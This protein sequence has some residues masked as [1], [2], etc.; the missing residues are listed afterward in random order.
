[1]A[2]RESASV[3]ESRGKGGLLRRR[4]HMSA[5]TGNIAPAEWL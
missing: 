4:W 3:A 2:S 1:M 5:L